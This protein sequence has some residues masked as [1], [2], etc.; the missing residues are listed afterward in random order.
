MVTSWL[1]F[2]TDLTDNYPSEI[3]YSYFA[4]TEVRCNVVLD[5]YGTGTNETNIHH[6]ILLPL[7]YGMM[8]ERWY[9][10]AKIWFL[11]DKTISSGSFPKFVDNITY[12]NHNYP[13]SFHRSGYPVT[14]PDYNIQYYS[15]GATSDPSFH[16]FGKFTGNDYVPVSQD[17]LYGAGTTLKQLIIDALPQYTLTGGNSGGQTHSI[18]S[19]STYIHIPSNSYWFASTKESEG[20]TTD[21]GIDYTPP[22]VTGDGISIMANARKKKRD[23]LW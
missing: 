11:I 15:Q 19:S 10:G 14:P 12:P 9:S 7:N 5:P 20:G 13:Q 4:N 18:Y 21:P 23:F 16:N 6:N 2:I 1:D 3:C 8:F 17:D 22:I